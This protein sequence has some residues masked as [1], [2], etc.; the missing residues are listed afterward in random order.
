M[1]GARAREQVF[2]HVANNALNIAETNELQVLYFAPQGR[3]TF[4][5][6]LKRRAGVGVFDEFANGACG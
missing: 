1:T 5:P 6:A 3:K 4:A 2:N